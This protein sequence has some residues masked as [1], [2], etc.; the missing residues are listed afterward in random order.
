MGPL[1]PYAIVLFISFAVNLILGSVILSIDARN[2]VN[3]VYAV[4]T[5]SLAYWGLMKATTMLSPTA[6]TAEIFFRLSGPGWCML[7][8]LYLHFITAFVDRLHPRWVKILIGCVYAVCITLSALLWVDDLMCVGLKEA[9][10]GYSDMPGPVYRYVFQP[11]FI[12]SFVVGIAELLW[13]SRSMVGHDERARAFLVLLGMLFPLVGGTVT[14]MVLPSLDIYVVELAVPLTT[15]NAA[16]VAFAMWRYKFLSITVEYAASTI[17]NTMGDSLMVLGPGGRIRLVNPATLDILGYR[18]D[19]LIGKHIND[20]LVQEP[21]DDRLRA[22]LADQGTIK[23][24][25]DYRSRGDNLIAVSMSMS[26]LEGRKNRIVGYVCVGKDIRETRKLITEIE[27]AKEE[28]EKIAVTD[29]LTDLYNRRYLMMKLKEELLRSNRYQHP[30][31]L[32]IIDLDGFKAIND[33]LGHEEGDR[34]LVMVAEALREQVRETDTVARIGGDEFVIVLSE[35]AID[36]AI[37]MTQ[38]IKERVVRDFP[39]KYRSVTASYGIS[40]F[41]PSDPRPDQEKLLRAADWALL[42]A[43]RTGKDRIVHSDLQKARES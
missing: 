26:M 21:F 30:F 43:K 8:A 4:L 40:T 16:I 37:S 24:E 42:N 3:R 31:S 14:N 13:F 36:E 22:R 20:V 32:V 17:I 19:D 9:Y 34:V 27:D 29:P 28:L 18:S 6:E 39:E 1:T 5:F 25:V 35:T 11:F 2:H 33:Q 10:W 15:L 12:G 23:M 41:D 7:P 38:R